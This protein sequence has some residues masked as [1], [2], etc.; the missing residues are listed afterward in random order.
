MQSKYT[1]VHITTVLHITACHTY[2]PVN[3]YTEMHLLLLPF[4]QLLVHVF[5]HKAMDLIFYYIDLNRNQDVLLAFDA[6]KVSFLPSGYIVSYLLTVPR[7]VIILQ[8]HS[9]PL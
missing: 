4:F 2:I 8:D 9:K 6:L 3:V 7:L 1:S 5:E